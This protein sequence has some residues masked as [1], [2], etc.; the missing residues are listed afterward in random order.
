MEY[1]GPI[2][3]AKCEAFIGAKHEN[4]Y[5]VRGMN[6]WWGAGGVGG[7]WCG[8][9]GGGGGGGVESTVGICWLVGVYSPRSSPQ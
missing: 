6:L 9:G 2:I 3:T 8:G 4:C 7:G 5:L 1:T